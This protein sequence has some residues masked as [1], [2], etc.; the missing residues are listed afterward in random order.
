MGK[1]LNYQNIQINTPDV[2]TEEEQLF[3][4]PID[5]TEDD[6]ESGDEVLAEE[7]VEITTEE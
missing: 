7:H 2:A 5:M 3:E 1:Y 4:E 6:D